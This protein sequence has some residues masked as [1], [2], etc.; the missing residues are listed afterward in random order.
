M[1]V[2]EYECRSCQHRFDKKQGFHDKPVA[3]CP[4]CQGKARRLFHPS[5]IIFKGSGFYVTDHRKNGGSEATPEKKESK[6]D[7]SAKGKSESA[8]P[9]S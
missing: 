7:S 9:K 2:Y 1:P 6:G 8:D 5:P 3:E 4:Q